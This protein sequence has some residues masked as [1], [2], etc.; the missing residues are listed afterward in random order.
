MVSGISEVAVVYVSQR[1]W[2]CDSQFIP[3]GPSATSRF[4]RG[5]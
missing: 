2:L 4:L 5:R 3:D 1:W